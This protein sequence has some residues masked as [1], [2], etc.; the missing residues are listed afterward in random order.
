MQIKELINL[1]RYK[2]RIHSRPCNYF[3]TIE[4]AALLIICFSLKRVEYFVD[5]GKYLFIIILSQ[6]YL[7]SSGE[8]T[9]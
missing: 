1:S 6:V 2:E 4:Y 5:S 7:P 9:G 3:K 8:H